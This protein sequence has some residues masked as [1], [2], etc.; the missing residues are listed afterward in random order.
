MTTEVEKELKRIGDDVK[1]MAEA[2]Q[3]EIKAH[4][5]LSE[6]TKAKVDQLLTQQ[7]ELRANLQ[8]AEQKLAMLEQGGATAERP[9]SLG[10]QVTEAD[11]FADWA[12]SPSAKFRVGVQAAITSGSDSAGELIQPTR[13]PGIVAPQNQ[14]LRIRDLLSW[15]RTGSNS[16]EFIREEGF[17]NSAAPVAENPSTAKPQS[18]LSFEAASAPVVTIAHWVHATKQVLADIPMLQSY[19]NG[20][21]IY[22]LKLVEDRQLLKG[23]GVGLN[24]NGIYTQASSYANPGVTVANETAIDRLRLA[25]LQAELAEYDADGIVLSPI[26]W[27]GIELLKTSDNAYLFANPRAV[28][29]PGLWGRSV[30]STQAMDAGEFLVGSFQQGAQGWDREDVSVSVATQDQDDFVKN[31]VKILVE[32]RLGLTVYRPEA[33]VKGT[34]GA[35]P[36]ASSTPP[37]SS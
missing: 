8:N 11:G 10:E 21:L 7:G 20:R 13:V 1:S 16:I 30:V 22:G 3:K 19:I 32:E 35:A 36:P 31:M 14:R 23:S 9:R 18:S 12:K 26:D 33:F 28:A 2:A 4:A 6:E 27:T 17:T 37:A 15:G 34:F 5:A 24:I 29:T 25:I